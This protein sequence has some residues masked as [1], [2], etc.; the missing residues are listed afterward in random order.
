MRARASCNGAACHLVLEVSWLQALRDLYQGLL[1]TECD[2]VAHRTP[3]GRACARAARRQ[4]SSAT[5]RG[6]NDDGLAGRPD[7]QQRASSTRGASVRCRKY[8][9]P[10]VGVR[11]GEAVGQRSARTRFMLV[12]SAAGRRRLRRTGPKGTLRLSLVSASRS[13][14]ARC[15]SLTI[16]DGT[17][18]RFAV[19]RALPV[20]GQPSGAGTRLSTALC[21]VSV[22][23]HTY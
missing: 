4:R 12:G 8:I 9:Q 10:G 22:H 23:G 11:G 14:A 19:E 3:H 15:L 21:S 2:I 7:N 5:D 17:V 20:G 16:N 18:S 13:G 6:S 1:I